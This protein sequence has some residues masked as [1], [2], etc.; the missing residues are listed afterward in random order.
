MSFLLFLFSKELWRFKVKESMLFVEQKYKVNK[1]DTQT[2][3]KN[4]R[5]AFREMKHVLQL[6]EELRIKV[7]L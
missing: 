6:V 1:N 5:Y 3:M 4:P 7:K 2:K